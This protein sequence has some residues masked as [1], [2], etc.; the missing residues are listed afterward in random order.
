[1]SLLGAAIVKEVTSTSPM[2]TPELAASLP[3]ALVPAGRA[4]VI[5]VT[6]PTVVTVA[7]V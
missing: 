2:S 3:M 6:A 5:E 7:N 4:L 1:M